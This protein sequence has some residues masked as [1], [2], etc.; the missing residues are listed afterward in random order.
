M[1]KVNVL[2]LIASLCWFFWSLLNIFEL[3]IE[4]PF[5]LSVCGIF[6]ILA[7]VVVHLVILIKEIIDRKKKK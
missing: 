6:F 4:V 1:K 3:F 7:A 5:I 2:W